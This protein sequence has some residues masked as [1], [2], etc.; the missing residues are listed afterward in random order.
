VCPDP[1]HAGNLLDDPSFEDGLPDGYWRTYPEGQVFQT[2][3][4]TPD[5]CAFACGDRVARFQPVAPPDAQASVAFLQTVTG[6]QI[7]ELGGTLEVSTHLRVAGKSSPYF[8]IA[9]NGYNVGGQIVGL[10]SNGAFVA[11]DYPVHLTD[12]RRTGA[13]FD[14]WL[15]ENLSPG[16]QEDI[17]VD[18]TSV[19]YVPPPGASLL[20]DGWFEGVGLAAWTTVGSWSTGGGGRCGAATP[21]AS[22]T[23]ASV[24]VVA[25][26]TARLTA[27]KQGPFANLGALRFGGA[28]STLAPLDVTLRVTATA[29]DQTTESAVAASLGSDGGWVAATG[30]LSPTKEVASVALELEVTNPTG[31]SASLLADCFSLRAAPP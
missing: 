29:T 2:V 31:E 11:T 3:P 12:P 21:I 6:K 23:A 28:W 24:A 14:L 20:G 18:C 19:R 27:T 30:A 17:H 26:E 10:P 15:H 16:A 4:A 1:V 8:A 13:W 5:D 25:G 22:D 9:V 7:V